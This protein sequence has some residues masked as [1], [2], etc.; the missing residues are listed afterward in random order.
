MNPG[1]DELLDDDG[2]ALKRRATKQRR[3]LLRSLVPLGCRLPVP[4]PVLSAFRRDTTRFVVRIAPR[5]RRG[6]RTQ[7][8][9]DRRGPKT[10]DVRREGKRTGSDEDPRRRERADERLPERPSHS[11][12]HRDPG[13]P[14]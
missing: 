13:V 11:S 1:V 3:A 9:D 2:V 12:V 14:L 7:L 5:E 4:V 8:P 6:A 10:S